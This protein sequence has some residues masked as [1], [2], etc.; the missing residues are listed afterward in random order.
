MGPRMVDLDEIFQPSAAG[1]RDRPG[2]PA[3]VLAP[4]VLRILIAGKE[5]DA[6]VD[7]LV[8]AVAR[9]QGPG[10]FMRS[11]VYELAAE[12]A[13]V[14]EE[15][16]TKG[17]AEAA[18]TGLD[19]DEKAMALQIALVAVFSSPQGGDAD[20]GVLS[21]IAERMGVSEEAFSHA[22]DSARRAVAEP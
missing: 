22:Y 1:E 17:L 20:I 14:A 10:G 13:R 15:V 18:K 2:V 5:I 6:E 12:L 8:A 9:L 21:A 16:G 7:A 4:A 11:F 3:L 19:P